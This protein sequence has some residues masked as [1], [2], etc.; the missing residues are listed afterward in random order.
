MKFN[1]K[2]IKVLFAFVVIIGI[3]FWA[4]NT[5]RPRSYE[6]TD[7]NFG[8][9]DGTVSITNPSEQSTSVQLVGSGSRTF[10]VSSTSEDIS[11]TS[12]RQGSGSSSTQL[13]EFE[14]PSGANEFTVSRGLDVNFIATTSSTLQAIVNPVSDSAYN[15]ILIATIAIILG[16]LFYASNASEHIW[17]SW[18]RGQLGFAEAVSN[19][20]VPA[21]VIVDG[22]QGKNHKSFGDN[23]SK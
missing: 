18:L 8:I 16:S 4:V 5:I 1:W 19:E 3:T 20:G 23:R 11:G 10:R 14:L 22:G 15:A 12:A 9:G 21:P 17:M 6:G 7:L 13:F 2:T